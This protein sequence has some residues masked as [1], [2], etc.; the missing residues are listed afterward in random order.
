VECSIKKG[1]C[2]ARRGLILL[3]DAG[4]GS[5]NETWSL[6]CHSRRT[7][8]LNIWEILRRAPEPGMKRKDTT[9]IL[10]QR[11]GKKKTGQRFEDWEG[12]GK[13]VNLARMLGGGVLGGDQGC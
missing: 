11:N 9:L 6:Y 12:S 1:R 5:E 2:A 8:G 7:R 13:G 4:R 10:P 3:G